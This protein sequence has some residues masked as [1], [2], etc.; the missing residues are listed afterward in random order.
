MTNGLIP[1][2]LHDA[3]LFSS[4]KLFNASQDG[5]L[6][7]AIATIRAVVKTLDTVLS[8]QGQSNDSTR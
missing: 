1:P 8:E 7:Y 6:D 5:N 2:A 3:M 4:K